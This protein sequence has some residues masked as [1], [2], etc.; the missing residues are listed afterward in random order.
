MSVYES[1]QALVSEVVNRLV[2]LLD[3]ALRHHGRCVLGLS[4]GR[5]PVPVFERLTAQSGID[6]NR[7]HLIWCDE[8]CVPPDHPASNYGVARAKLVDG[9]GIPA[10]N[11][12]RIRGEARP[13]DAAD[14][15]EVEMHRLL[16]H[17]GRPDVLLLGMG[18]D[19][20]TAS[21]FPRHQALTETD[22]WFV[23]VHVAASPPWRVTATFPFLNR[24]SHILFLVVGREKAD[25]LARIRAGEPLPAG[26]LRPT[27]GV[28]EW[29][30]GP[31]AGRGP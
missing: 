19:G 27:D 21:L 10:D 23:P 4:G 28:V 7:I 31:D 20:H 29:H 8:R 9:I 25:A 22:R 13:L 17:H 5:T 15:Y 3:V 18:Q 1:P 6:W 26:A 11:I 30:V 2:V 14:H 16:G 24:A 12:H